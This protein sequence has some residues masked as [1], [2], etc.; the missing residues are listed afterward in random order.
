VINIF[1]VSDIVLGLCCLVIA[2]FALFTDKIPPVRRKAVAALMFVSV[3]I[4]LT[5]LA[6]DAGFAVPPRRFLVAAIYIA[7][8]SKGL[9]LGWMTAFLF[10]RQLR[11]EKA[12]AAEPDLKSG[13]PLRCGSDHD[14]PV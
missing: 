11:S 8:G 5:N 12:G 9:V 3:V 10:F 6:M 4:A 14:R 13:P 7:G 1:S 2:S